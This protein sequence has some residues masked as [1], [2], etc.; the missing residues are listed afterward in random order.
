MRVVSYRGRL[1]HFEAD[2]PTMHSLLAD[3]YTQKM[4]VLNLTYMIFKATVALK[5]V[6]IRCLVFS[7]MFVN[8]GGV[9]AVSGM[10]WWRLRPHASCL[11]HSLPPSLSL[12]RSRS[13]SPS[14]NQ[15]CCTQRMQKHAVW[16]EKPRCNFPLHL[17]PIFA[18]C[19]CPPLIPISTLSLLPSLPC[20]GPLILDGFP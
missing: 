20:H 5:S 10:A 1:I 2:N 4:C 19:P 8:G 15:P 14:M 17:F 9:V 3:G 6:D 16:R 13:L 7:F 11:K 12:S 18:F